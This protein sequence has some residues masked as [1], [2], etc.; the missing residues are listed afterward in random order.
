[1][2]K[3]RKF[4]FNVTIFINKTN[5]YHIVYHIPLYVSNILNFSKGNAEELLPD[6]DTSLYGF[7]LSETV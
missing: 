3:I 5:K 4:H 7:T 2:K 1:M 6:S